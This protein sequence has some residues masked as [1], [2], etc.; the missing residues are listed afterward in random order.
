MIYLNLFA[1]MILTFVLLNDFKG[2]L[3]DA[4]MG[5]LVVLNFGLF[6]KP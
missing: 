1:A 2:S 3:M 4:L 5:A 6:L